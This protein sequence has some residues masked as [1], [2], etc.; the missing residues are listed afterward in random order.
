MQKMQPSQDPSSSF[1]ELAKESEALHWGGGETMVQWT[2]SG[3]PENMRCLQSQACWPVGTGLLSTKK[4][5]KGE[6]L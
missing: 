5:M 4:T 2:V 3:F 1:P 6:S